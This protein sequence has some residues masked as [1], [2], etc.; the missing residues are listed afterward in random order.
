MMKNQLAGLM[1][2]AQAMQDNLKKAQEER[3]KGNPWVDTGGSSHACSPGD[4]TPAGTVVNG[5]RKVVKASMF[6]Q[7]CM[8][9][10]AR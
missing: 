1:K 2:Q 7:T 6:G 3:S 8:W 10:P 4:T 5:Y 9:E